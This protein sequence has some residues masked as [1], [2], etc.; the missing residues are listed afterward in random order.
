VTSKNDRVGK[1]PH[2]QL[3]KK[4]GMPNK[5]ADRSK[6]AAQHGSGI[7]SVLDIIAERNGFNAT[8]VNKIG[9]AGNKITTKKMGSSSRYG[10]RYD[11]SAIWQIPDYVQL[12][13]DA[14]AYNKE[15]LNKPEREKIQSFLEK[16]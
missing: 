6:E 7:H 5:Y 8:L 14:I 13:L 16:I 4:I 12:Y 1:H 11:R 10:Y 15:M 2:R 3:A 9:Y